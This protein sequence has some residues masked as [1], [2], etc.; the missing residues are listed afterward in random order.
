MQKNTLVDME[1]ITKIYGNHRALDR[2][3]FDLLPGEVHCLVGE[4]GA[5]K[6]T[7]IKILSGAISPDDGLIKIEGEEVRELSPRQSIELGISTIYQDAELVDS[8]TVADNVYLG[9]ELTGRI[10][11]VVDSRTQ[12]KRVEETIDALKMNLPTGILV[13]EL[14]ASQKQM[15][16]I[17]KALYKDAKVLIM[18]EP[19]SSLGMDETEALMKIVRN[20]RDRGIG[21]IY[22]SHYLE[23]IFEIGDRVTVLKDG[24]SMG[25]FSIDSISVEEIIRKMV[26]RDAS[27]FYT[28]RKVNIG[29]VALE[30]RNITRYG[31]VDN[32]SFSVR[33]GEVFGIGGLVGSG[34]SELVNILFGADRADSGEIVLNDKRL[35]IKSPQ[36]AV[37]CGIALITEDRKK[38][39]MLGGRDV[40]ENT[41][42]VHSENFRGF[43][44]NLKE[45][46][47][48][49]DEI[50]NRLSVAV[51]ER[52]QKIEELS[53]GNQQK[54]VIGRWLVDDSD[55]YI[56]DEPTKGVDIGAREQIYELIIELAE[57]GK[58]IIM[59]SSDLP[60][61]LSM[62][63]RI[64][65]MRN[66]R[67][68][69]IVENKDIEEEDM[70]KRFIGV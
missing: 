69:E 5:G 61:L 9:D 36:D 26:G 13:E 20:L 23:E 18:D 1:N 66:G 42:L 16:Q 45:E 53:G 62:S 51:Q 19:T 34:R 30:V 12:M 65:V 22:I 17:V 54:I 21:I 32:V 14:S 57:K 70:I 67:L 2:V 38:L 40:V 43:L 39:A 11:F 41:A 7:L 55:V 8:L 35:R 59:I 47:K 58:C 33:K 10:P 29:N 64:G 31:V 25:T 63:D 28:R 4:N 24:T 15:L 50:V 27:L 3:S 48:L 46:D 68:V 44:L 52:S 56:F 37:K 49:T 60:E 6:S